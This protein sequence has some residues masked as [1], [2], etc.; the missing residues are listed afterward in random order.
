MAATNVDPA[1][2]VKSG[3]LREDL[4]YRLNVFTIALPP[5]RDRKEDLPLLV[6]TSSRNSICA[7]RRP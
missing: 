4:Y 5:L 1:G 6:Q 3:K 2:A 7:T